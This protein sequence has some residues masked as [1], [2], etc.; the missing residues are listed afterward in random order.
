MPSGES[1]TSGE[2]GRVT[3]RVDGTSEQVKRGEQ[4]PPIL[5]RQIGQ[6]FGSMPS[7]RC[8]C[9]MRAAAC[10][11]AIAAAAALA[12]ASAAPLAACAAEKHAA[13]TASSS[14]GGGVISAMASPLN[15]ALIASNI[16]PT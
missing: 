11:A 1:V 4:N 2:Q 16:V 14:L 15:T 8:C 13:I 9:A 10:A 7:M 6:M 5:F 3:S 12:E